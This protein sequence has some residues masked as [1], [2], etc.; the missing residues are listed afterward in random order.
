[1]P[2]RKVVA[3]SIHCG[4]MA[5][6]PSE[7]P[8]ARFGQGGPIHASI[9]LVVETLAHAGRCGRVAVLPTRPRGGPDQSARPVGQREAPAGPAA[10]PHPPTPPAAPPPPTPP[11]PPPP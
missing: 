4:R 10:S 8:A 6:S 7:P 11:P 3:K 2:N 5:T 1:M 9:E